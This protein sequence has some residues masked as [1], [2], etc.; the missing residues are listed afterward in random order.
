MVRRRLGRREK[1]KKSAE[2]GEGGQGG[3]K[4][5]GKKGES[6]VKLCN[7]KNSTQEESPVSMSHGDSR[8]RVPY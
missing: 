5:E 7:L 2:K 6:S 3:K 8:H 1:V 4:K